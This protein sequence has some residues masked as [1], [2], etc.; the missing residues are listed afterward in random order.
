MKEDN[1]ES[2]FKFY[3]ICFILVIIFLF[4]FLNNK[5]EVIQK[6]GNIERINNIIDNIKVI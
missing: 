3:I 4:Y 1:S 5:E 6:G 2:S